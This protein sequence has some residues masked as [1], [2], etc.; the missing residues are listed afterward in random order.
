MCVCMA[1]LH[2]MYVCMYTASL[3]HSS[4]FRVYSLSLTNS[5]SIHSE[6]SFTPNIYTYLPSSSLLGM[7]A[8]NACTYVGPIDQGR[9]ATAFMYVC[10]YTFMYL[11]S[12]VCKSEYVWI[13]EY[14][15]GLLKTNK[16]TE[17]LIDVEYSSISIIL[18]DS[19]TLRCMHARSVL[20]P[21]TVV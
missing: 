10:M 13:T 18:C 21:F 4:S 15:W 6:N 7:R 16:F 9:C 1:S 5:P 12:C 17:T 3:L 14:V 2:V 20:T 8:W 19:M 11:N